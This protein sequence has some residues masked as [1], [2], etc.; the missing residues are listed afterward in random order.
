MLFST[1][2]YLNTLLHGFV[3]DDNDFIV[4]SPYIQDW[5]N[6]LNFITA[7]YL[8]H[9]WDNLDVNRPLMVIS[10]IL[11][12]AIWKLNPMGYHLTNL[13]LHVANTVIVLYLLNSIFWDRRIAVFSALLFAVHPIHVQAVNVISFRE[14][15][16]VTLF[17]LLSLACVVKSLNYSKDKGYFLLSIL[18]YLLALLSKEMALTLPLVILMYIRLWKRKCP[19][20]PI[21]AGYLFI[22]V[23]YLLFFFYVQQFSTMVILERPLLERLYGTLVI[24]GR[25][26][27]LHLFP[28]GL[29]PDYGQSPFFLATAI[30]I[31]VA[32]IV[33]SL[34]SWT[35]YR[36]II[37]P[38]PA[39]FPL[40]WFFITLLPVMNV[41]QIANSVAERYLYLPSLGP[42]VAI[43]MAGVFLLDKKYKYVLTVLITIASL[44]LFLTVKD[45][46]VWRDST[47]LW[48]Y[49][50]K[51]LP[52]TADKAYYNRGMG[53]G[54][55]GRYQLAI[56]DF[57][58][59]I[60]IHPKYSNAYNNRGNAYANLGDYRQAIRDF[61][62]AIE[63]EPRNAE[64]YYNLGLAYSVLGN[65]EQANR[66]YKEAARLGLR[67]AQG[68]K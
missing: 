61:T 60:E 6:L 62:R 67:E 10:L 31:A 37:N 68:Y 1:V 4:G 25:Y 40:M 12:F 63:V 27:W 58:K 17:Y 38:S 36:L 51:L 33:I 32:G 46:T 54:I 52:D 50:I 66:Y 39:V 56:K 59:A 55:Q 41:I 20:W 8:K 14:D 21:Y 28:I 13:M 45:N 64:A 11:D 16:L 29:I 22:T 19:P 65:V 7:D 47:A 24:S 15:L 23:I 2:A 34:A 26:L 53:F 44:F 42:I 57:S 5:K 18:F 43:A 35:L 9:S 49:E 48:D 30:N 3:W